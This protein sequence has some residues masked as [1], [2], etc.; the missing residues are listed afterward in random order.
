[1]QDYNFSL[2][3]V[4]KTPEIMNLIQEKN[5]IEINNDNYEEI[6]NN[7]SNYIEIEDV[8]FNTSKHPFLFNFVKG[9][10]DH[11][12]KEFN[13]IFTEV[14]SKNDLRNFHIKTKSFCDVKNKI[15]DGFKKFFNETEEKLHN[16][17][18]EKFDDFRGNLHFVD[19]KDLLNL[20]IETF[21]K[22]NKNEPD[23]E[24][25]KNQY[26]KKIKNLICENGYSLSLKLDTIKLLSGLESELSSKSSNQIQNFLHIDYDCPEEII[27]LE[28][29]EETSMFPKFTIIHP[30]LEI[31]GKP[32]FYPTLCGCLI[33]FPKACEKLLGVFF[34]ENLDQQKDFDILKHP[35]T[36][37][38]SLFEYLHSKN[39]KTNNDIKNFVDSKT[40]QELR[41][42]YKDF[43]E[44]FFEN[45]ESKKLTS[46]Y[47]QSH[48]D[49]KN[50][51]IEKIVNDF[52]NGSLD[53]IDQSNPMH[54]FDSK[55][56]ILTAG[57]LNS[58]NINGKVDIPTWKI[59][60]DKN[61]N[62]KHNIFDQINNGLSFI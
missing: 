62:A 3:W 7:L 42:D 36:Q 32:H 14:L 21:E 59:A 44:I 24:N 51:S 47:I 27:N 5:H 2:T 12:D 49:F 33:Y 22:Y 61:Q 45:I 9:A 31:D 19:Y 48:F 23:F 52:L 26:E 8:I 37:L 41:D 57:K 53:S 30:C 34:E 56:E 60:P 13:T 35:E 54:F 11:P 28:L 40:Y 39:L 50:F 16:S 29:K 20:S 58:G 1:M 18:S 46:R 15:H 4:I 43:N 38:E 10:V 55:G 6:F 25:L 17:L